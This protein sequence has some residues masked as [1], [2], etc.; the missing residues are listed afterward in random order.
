MKH[1]LTKKVHI[2]S[3]IQILTL[4]SQFFEKL[5][6]WVKFSEFFTP[7]KYI[8]TSQLQI[9]RNPREYSICRKSKFFLEIIF[10][11]QIWV[12]YKFLTM[13]H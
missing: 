5:E 7:G 10:F 13:V 2:W 6:Q 9:P 12:I 8:F 1:F 11:L 3:K 4:S